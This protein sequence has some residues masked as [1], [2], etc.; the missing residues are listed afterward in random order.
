M[1]RDYLREN[2]IF[3]FGITV[4]IIG[5]VFTSFYKLSE[6]PVT[7][8]DEGLIV[9]TS[10]NLV[11]QGV[12]GFQTA[13]NTI[14][15]PSF[16]STSFPVTYPIA[17]S[18][19]I[20]GI[21]LFN[22]RMVMAVYII[23]LVTTV[24]FLFKNKIKEQLIW[25]LLLLGSFPPLYGH[26]KNVLGEIPGLFWVL[27][28]ALFLK[29]IE[30]GKSEWV[31]WV[32]F[33]LSFGMAL[34]TK[35][36]FILTLPG[37]FLVIWYLWK[38]DDGDI[39]KKI[40]LLGLSSFIP[41]LIWFFTQFFATDGVSAILRYYSNPHSVNIIQAIITNLKDFVSNPRTLFVGGTFLL[42]TYSLIYSCYKSKKISLVEI[43]LYSLSLFVFVLY[44]RNPPYYR[45]FFITEALSLIFLTINLS[46]G[47]FD[48]VWIKN[49][50]RVFLG[51]L[52]VFQLYQLSFNSWVAGSYQSH[53]T[54]IMTEVIGSITSD[55][56][57]FFYQA[58]EA[59]IFLKHFNYY[60][61][62]SGTVSTEFG[63]D[64]LNLIRERRDI[65]VVT[66][67]DLVATRP[68]L[69][70]NYKTKKEFDR[71]VLLEK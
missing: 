50:V 21:S 52:V 59:V 13:P 24:L 15:S 36:I 7:W 70:S 1:I 26:G 4:I 69:F 46:R 38:K 44:F 61:Y 41:I 3:S 66:R 8:T 12:Y 45:Y 48:K 30:E 40:G 5:V 68:D 23:F 6:S 62:F 14:I 39:Y 53:K 16:I 22:A 33:S 58:P 37:V 49:I 54:K 29:K 28:S 60:Q 11:G 56:T 35:P 57:I 32:L 25:T 55:K 42:W 20:F 63:Q 18:F 17:L 47:Y 64:N 71:Y 31:N 43:Y 9:Q 19:K 67:G 10:Q 2:L 51:L 65:L 27:L 34:V